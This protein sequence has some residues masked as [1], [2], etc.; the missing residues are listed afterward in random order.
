MIDLGLTK[1]MISGLVRRGVLRR[2]APQVF[3]ICGAPMTRRQQLRIGLLALGDESWIS[4]EAAAVLHRL[5]T[6]RGSGRWGVRTIDALLP[7]SGGHSMLERRFLEL[8]REAGLPR[9]RTQVVHRKGNRHIARVD[10]LFDDHGIV[11]EVNGRR[12]H[13][14]DAE[15]ERDGQRRGELTDLGLLVYEYTWNEVTTDPYGVARTLR[16]R[17]AAHDRLRTQGVS[18]APYTGYAN[19]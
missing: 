19:G 17:L 15:R 4:F 1:D 16:E 14:S 12:G 11:I 6:L 18:P 10:F 5:E 9:P 13:A 8:V 3:V 7:D 2:V